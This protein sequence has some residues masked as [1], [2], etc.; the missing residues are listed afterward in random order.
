[1]LVGGSTV[2]SFMN[3]RAEQEMNMV[4]EKDMNMVA[5]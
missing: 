1:M 5:E 4:A 3:M 2:I